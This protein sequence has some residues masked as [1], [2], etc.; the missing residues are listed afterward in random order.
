MNLRPW[1]QMKM[2]RDPEGA[3]CPAFSSGRMY[4][5]EATGTRTKSFG[6]SP[7]LTGSEVVI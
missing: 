1:R 2:A 7:S 5:R 4:D 6:W 3:E